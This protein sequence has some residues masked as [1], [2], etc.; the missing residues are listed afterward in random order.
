MATESPWGSPKATDEDGPE[1]AFERTM[2]KAERDDAAEAAAR[3][4]RAERPRLGVLA[5]PRAPDNIDVRKA[6]M[7]RVE[8]GEISLG[9]AQ[10]QVL[11]LKRTRKRM[12]REG[13]L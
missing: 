5:D 2:R 10:R 9:E 12:E 1:A 6:L 8:S 11:A 13:K 3:K 7:A 4:A